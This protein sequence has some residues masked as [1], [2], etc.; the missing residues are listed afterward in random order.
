LQFLDINIINKIKQ[1][2]RFI[3][4]GIARFKFYHTTG[5]KITIYLFYLKKTICKIV[6]QQNGFASRFMSVSAEQFE[7][8]VRYCEVLYKN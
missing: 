3:L 6:L 7:K 4:A 8:I 2:S 1:M 5:Q